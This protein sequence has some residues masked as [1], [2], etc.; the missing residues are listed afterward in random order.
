MY[1]HS[2]IRK[3]CFTVV[4]GNPVESRYDRIIERYGGRIVGIHK[5]HTMLPDGRLYDEKMY[6]ILRTDYMKHRKKADNAD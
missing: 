4:V 1:S 6:E 2:S 3:I 5:E